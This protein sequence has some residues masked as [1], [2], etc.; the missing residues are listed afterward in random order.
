[1]YRVYNIL[2]S[3]FCCIWVIDVEKGDRS[4]VPH[5]HALSITLLDMRV[6]IHLF[7]ISRCFSSRSCY[8]LKSIFSLDLAVLGIYNHC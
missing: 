5:N 3:N 1:M 8:R 2:I 4:L 6:T 7:L